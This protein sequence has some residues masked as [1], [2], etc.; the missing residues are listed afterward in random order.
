MDLLSLDPG[1][2]WERQLY[3]EIDQC[4]LFLLFWSNEA[5]NS[6]W[7]NLE[8]EYA[9]ERIKNHAS[10]YSPRPEIQPII[11]EGPPPPPPPDSLADRHFNDPFLYLIASIEKLNAARPVN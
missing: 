7:V 4:D 9:L 5:R 3:S 11:I 10:P 6:K 1:Q 8:I 2:R